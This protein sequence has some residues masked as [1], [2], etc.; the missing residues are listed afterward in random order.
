[1][2]IL[3]EYSLQTFSIV[4]MQTGLAQKSETSRKPRQVVEPI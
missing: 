1:M 2:R 3:R 4:E